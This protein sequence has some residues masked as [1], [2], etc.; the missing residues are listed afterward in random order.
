ML[1][2]QKKQ[3]TRNTVTPQLVCGVDIVEIE[4]F[5]RVLKTGGQQ[6][7]RRIYT[8]AELAFCANRLPQLAARFAA[9]EAISKALGTGIQGI[10]WREIE[11][12]SDQYSCPFVSLYGGAAKKA[13]QNCIVTWAISLSHSQH[14]A[15][16]FVIASRMETP[17]GFS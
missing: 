13:E 15:I 9:K 16:A 17:N 8:E 11:I 10:D 7:L 4:R 1:A 14:V 6:F 5:A 2:R 12:V 3:G